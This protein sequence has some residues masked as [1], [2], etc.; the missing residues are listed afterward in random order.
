MKKKEIEVK[1]R[2][3]AS[4]RNNERSKVKTRKGAL[5]KKN[6]FKMKTRKGRLETKGGFG[7]KTH[8]GRPKYVNLIQAS[9]KVPSRKSA[10]FRGNLTSV[11]IITGVEV[12]STKE[13]I[14]ENCE[15]GI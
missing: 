10:L 15:V 13:D 5:G 7:S 12:F 6:G 8:K 4:R 14:G 3:G 9:L 11:N 2:K 1:T